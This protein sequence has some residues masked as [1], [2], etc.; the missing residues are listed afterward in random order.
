MIKSLDIN[1]LLQYDDPRDFPAYSVAEAAHYLN[2]PKATLRS[3]VLGTSYSASDGKTKRFR[4]VIELP[5]RDANLLSF[6]NLIEAHVLRSLRRVHNIQLPDIRKALVYVKKEFGW[7]RPL[8]EQDF[9]TDGVKLF[10]ERLGRLVDASSDGQVVI[11]EVMAAHLRRLEWEDRVVVRLYPFT[12]PSDF[13]SP[14][15]VLIDPRYSF[16]RPILKESHVA[17][18]I[19]AERYKSGDS[20]D[21]LAEDYAC[22]RLEIEEGLRC[23]L[24]LNAAA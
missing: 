1:S 6:F 11:E 21:A 15:S 23:E 19:I 24:Q 2:V 8:I 10:V 17:T 5:H 13:E 20:I 18:G 12:R 4:R 7:T 9:K 3:W 14:M 16:G 22:S